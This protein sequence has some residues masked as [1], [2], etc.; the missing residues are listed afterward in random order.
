MK[1]RLKKCLRAGRKHSS[2]GRDD[3][4]LFQNDGDW[5]G[6]VDELRSK[7][8]INV[9]RILEWRWAGDD[10]KEDGEDDVQCMTSAQ[11]VNT[12]RG[13]SLICQPSGS[14]PWMYIT[15]TQKKHTSIQALSP[16]ILADLL[17]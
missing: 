2:E 5:D 14:Q 6:E 11:R 3:D 7:K 9:D 12:G 1:Q 4:G 15:I 10:D 16:E 17:E 8:C 13:S